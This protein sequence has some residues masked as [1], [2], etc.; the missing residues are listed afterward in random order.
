MGVAG[1]LD[2]NL[3]RLQGPLAL[4]FTDRFGDHLAVE[5]VAHGGDVARLAGA[6]QIAGTAN[7][8]VAH[9]DPTDPSSVASPIVFSRS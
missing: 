9:G 1:D 8:E 6:E 5:V 4:E 3:D 2:R 7:L